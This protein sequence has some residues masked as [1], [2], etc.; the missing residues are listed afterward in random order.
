MNSMLIGRFFMCFADFRANFCV[1]DDFF[2]FTVSNGYRRNP[3]YLSK[4]MRLHFVTVSW[5]RII[6]LLRIMTK[7][8]ENWNYLQFFV[9]FCFLNKFLSLL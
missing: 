5:V 8:G 6:F 2:C 1:F 7:N 3:F 4:F 9:F